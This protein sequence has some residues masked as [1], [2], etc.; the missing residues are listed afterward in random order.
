MTVTWPSPPTVTS[1]DHPEVDDARVQLG[2]DDPGEHPAHV[3]GRRRGARD[4]LVDGCAGVVGVGAVES[5][6]GVLDVV[7]GHTE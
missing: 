4:R 2:V 7:E 5:H 6:R 1:F 3:V